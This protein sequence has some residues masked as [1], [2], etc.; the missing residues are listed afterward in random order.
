PLPGKLRL[1]ATNRRSRQ[2]RRNLGPA[3]HQLAGRRS[4]GSSL[5]RRPEESGNRDWKEIAVSCISA[6][7]PQLA[8]LADAIAQRVGQQRF[9]VWFTNSTRLDF[10]GDHLEIAVPNDFISEWINRNFSRTIQDAAFE[11]LGCSLPVTFHVV[12]QLFDGAGRNGSASRSTEAEDVGEP[13]VSRAS[14]GGTALLEPEIRTTPLVRTI[15]PAVLPRLAAGQPRLRH[16][17]ESFV[18]GP[19]SQLAHNACT[20]VAEFPG[21]QYNPLFIHG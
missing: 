12:P 18:V 15:R 14:R 8:R 9:Q 5:A 6:H 2:S 4:T 11:V 17:L 16:D 7:D 13:R 21:L 3:S 1:I 10:K 20:Y 19:G